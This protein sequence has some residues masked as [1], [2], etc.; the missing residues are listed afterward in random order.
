MNQQPIITPYENYL[1]QQS[2]QVS[3]SLNSNSIISH[4]GNIGALL[5]FACEEDFNSMAIA[6]MADKKKEDH[7]P[8]LKDYFDQGLTITKKYLQALEYK[9]QT[10]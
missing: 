7:N 8:Q 9:N 1:V 10:V 3:G 4:A 6:I 2:V 5:Y